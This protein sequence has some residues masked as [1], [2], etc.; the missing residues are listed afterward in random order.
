MPDLRRLA[1]LCLALLALAGCAGVAR[2]PAPEAVPARAHHPNGGAAGV[3]LLTVM[4]SR[5]NVGDH[6]ALLIGG[7]HRVIYD[8][9]GS[10]E[11]PAVARRHDVLYGISPA[12]EQVYLGYH[13]RATHHV[14]A[15]TLPLD[16]AQADA[17]I[18]LA[19]A[20]PAARPGF[21]AIRA[22]EVLRS[23][24]GMEGLSRSP[25]P[26]TLKESFAAVPG[27][28][29]RRIDA[30]D[31]PLWARTRGP[32]FVPDPGPNDSRRFEGSAPAAL[33]AAPGN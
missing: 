12:V 8:P 32:G 5:R 27:V 16:R 1:V 20:Q 25:F 22:S 18:A 19:E 4:D 17:L 21:C 14:V 3:T 24:P 6:A 30:T 13:A 10:F 9:A 7:S 31:V 28:K 23:L 26:R 2:A 15:Q 33:V 11:V 29:N